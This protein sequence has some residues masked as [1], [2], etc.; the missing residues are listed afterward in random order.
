MKASAN[1]VRPEQDE[2]ITSV[3]APTGNPPPSK[4]SISGTPNAT[5]GTTERCRGD[6]APGTRCANASS[7]C[8]RTEPAATKALSLRLVFALF[9]TRAQAYP[10]VSFIYLTLQEPRWTVLSQNNVSSLRNAFQPE[11]RR[12][13][14][15][16]HVPG[17]S[18]PLLVNWSPATWF[19]FETPSTV[20]L[21]SGKAC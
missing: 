8:L 17:T 7:I 10:E 14:E 9:D 12:T 4:A 11:M 1:E 15:I 5:R 20:V 16:A 13:P 18:H 2:P 3:M 21:M 6:N 19:T